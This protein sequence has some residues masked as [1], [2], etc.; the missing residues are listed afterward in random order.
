MLGQDIPHGTIW[1]APIP[2]CPAHGKM[3]YDM[4]TDRYICV[5]FDGEGCDFTID[6][7]HLE[8][9]PLGTVDLCRQNYRHHSTTPASWPRLTC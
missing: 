2:K 7:E 6:N 3:K 4:P 1:F 5:G 8:W 9:S